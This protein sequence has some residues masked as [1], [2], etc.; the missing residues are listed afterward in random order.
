MYKTVIKIFSNKKDA[1]LKSFHSTIGYEYRKI[2][3]ASN[4]PA[5]ITRKV[6]EVKSSKNIWKI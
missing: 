5:T 3:K 4:V 2:K 6:K 1:F